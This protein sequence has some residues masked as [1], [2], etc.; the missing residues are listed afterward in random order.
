MPKVAEPV[1]AGPRLFPP[2][3]FVP[4]LQ[5]PPP[6]H[7]LAQTVQQAVVKDRQR[8]FNALGVSVL[9]PGKWARAG[10][11]AQGLPERLKR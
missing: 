7:S 5:S 11:R 2:W 9:P 3:G 4:A 10:G 1:S 6:S 8:V